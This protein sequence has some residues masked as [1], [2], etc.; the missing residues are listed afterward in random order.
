[1]HNF[2]NLVVWQKSH[3]LVL[4][5]YTATASYP[6][7]ERYGLT[8]QTRRSAASAPANIAEGCGR[9]SRRELRRFMTIASGSTSELDYQLLLGLDLGYL[10][11]STYAE[12]QKRTEEVKKMLFSYIKKLPGGE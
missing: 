1:M 5:V 4:R 6:E 8:S 10:N 9:Y 11:E 7:T 3:E 2:R 12:L